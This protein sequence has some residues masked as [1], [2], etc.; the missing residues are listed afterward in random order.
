M[1]YFKILWMNSEILKILN[2]VVF[3]R[4][5]L[6]NLLNKQHLCKWLD[7]NDCLYKIKQKAL[8]A[9]LNISLFFKFQF[10]FM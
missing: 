4:F 3:H 8:I 2:N 5:V 6:I 10:P 9:Y 1:K 7:W